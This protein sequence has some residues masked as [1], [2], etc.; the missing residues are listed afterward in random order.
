[1]TKI[2]TNFVKSYIDKRKKR[3]T[4]PIKIIST[5]S[6]NAHIPYHSIKYDSK[7]N[8]WFSHHDIIK[9]SVTENFYMTRVNAIPFHVV[10]SLYVLYNVIS[11][12]F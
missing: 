12:S 4:D 9:R 10:L 8:K 6:G 1:M 2:F 5:E 11:I 7:S 3:N